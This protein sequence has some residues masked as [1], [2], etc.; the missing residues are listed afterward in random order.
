[1]KKR[2]SLQEPLGCSCVYEV[3]PEIFTCLNRSDQKSN[4]HS[5]W[6]DLAISTRSLTFDVWSVIVK[7]S[8]MYNN[9]L[10]V[11]SIKNYAIN[12]N[13]YLNIWCNC[14]YIITFVFPC[15]ITLYYIKDQLD[16]ALAVLFISHC[17]IT[18]H[19]SDAFCFHHQEY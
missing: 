8:N 16:A 18:L 12:Q 11:L 4:T 15:V 9:T 13:A 1:M 17:K 2:S 19:V 14:L 6:H 10:E 7:F 3:S 5:R